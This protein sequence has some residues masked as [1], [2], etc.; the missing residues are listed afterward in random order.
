MSAEYNEQLFLDFVKRTF[1]FDQTRGMSSRNFLKFELFQTE[2]QKHI[3]K[4]WQGLY[5]QVKDPSWPD[6]ESAAVA[7]QILPKHILD[8]IVLLHKGSL[9]D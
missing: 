2:Y 3:D 9:D 8:E 5:T 4:K 7:K 6:C 1:E